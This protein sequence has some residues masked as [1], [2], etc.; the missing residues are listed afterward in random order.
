V[1]TGEAGDSVVVPTAAVA[2]DATT[3]NTGSVMVIDS[4]S[5]AHEVK[6]TVGIRS[7][8]QMQITSGLHGGEI[9]VVEGNYALPDGAKVE[10]NAE[11]D[12]ENGESE[13]KDSE[14]AEPAKKDKD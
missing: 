5:V 12:R 8:D 10:V 1:Q 14:G 11:G 7:K 2:L 4:Q 13:K 6:V 9:V 3:A